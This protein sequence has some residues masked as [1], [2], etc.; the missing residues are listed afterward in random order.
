MLAN[1]VVGSAEI[2]EERH[3][4][5][6]QRA[7]K[8]A[9][10]EGDHAG[11]ARLQLGGDH[12]DLLERA[13]RLQMAFVE[14]VL[15]PLQ[16]RALKIERDHDDLVVV[17]RQLEQVLVEIG[18][19]VVRRRHRRILQQRREI[20]VPA[21]L[22][23][24]LPIARLERHVHVDIGGFLLQQRVQA[25]MGLRLDEGLDPDG[26]AGQLLE[27]VEIGKHGARPWMILGQERDRLPVIFLPV[28]SRLLRPHGQAGAGD[29]ERGERSQNE[30]PASPHHVS[31]FRLMFSV[32]V[33]P[34]PSRR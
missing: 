27:L 12:A 25:L 6:G 5:V 1:L 8:A 19:I 4:G 28:E 18:D 11:L 34:S 7:A 15:P 22:V 3:E 16:H 13:R 14:H 23:V 32:A 26:D 30:C 10:D 24:L 9:R 20:V 33:S 17:M 29:A 31:P 21:S 2:V